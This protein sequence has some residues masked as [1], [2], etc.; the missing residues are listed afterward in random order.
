MRNPKNNDVCSK[1]KLAVF[2]GAI[3]L[4]GAQAMADVLN[5]VIGSLLYEENFNTL[6]STIWTSVD[7][8]GCEIGLCGWGNQELEYYS[9]ANLSI[10]NVPFEPATKALAIEARREAHGTHAFTSGKITS[11]NKLQVK[12][13]LIEFRM[14]T[15]QVGVG[16][17][18][19]GWMLGTSLASWPSKGEL[20]IMEMGHS[21]A[22]MAGAGLA[23]S[24]INSYTASNAIFYATSA[25]TTGNASC[26]AS[27]AWQTK[28]AYVAS[29]PLTNRF[30]T[31]RM[32]WT[33]SQIRFT[34]VDAGVEHDM[35]AA[36]IPIT[37]ESSE[38][39]APFYFL[40]NLAVGGNFTDAA[41]DAQVTAP[42]A[43]RMYIDYI[44]VYQLNGLGEVKLGSQVKP[45]TGTF[46]VFT[47][48]TPTTNKQEA[49]VS[50]DIWIWNTTSTSA[51]TT[52]AYEGSNV[53]AWKY[54]APQW[55]GG[56]IASRQARDMG[57]FI[58]GNLKF[59]IKIP[60][61]VGFKIGIS[62]TYTNENY[63]NFPANTTTYGLVRDGNWAQATVPI[64]VL[65]GS[66]VALQSL[67]S[68]F[69]IVSID[70][71]PTANFEMAID[72]IVWECGTGAACQATSSASSVAASSVPASSIAASSV[73]A[74][75]V[76]ASSKPASS[77]A[78]SS[79][80][81]SSVPASSVPA[82][83]K[84]A[85]SV[86]ASSVAASSSV[87]SGN[88]YTVLS[89]TSIRFYANNAPWADI[90]FTVNGGPQQNVRMTVSGANN[91]YD[92]T[93]LT[94]GAV[95]NYNF[96]VGIAAGGAT[97]TAWASVTCCT[98]GASSAAPSSVAASSVA[99]SSVPASSKPASSVAP[100][101]VAASSVAA[102]S[103]PASSVAASSASSTAAAYGYTKLTTTSVKFFAN[104]SPWVDIHYTVSGG[105]QINVRMTHNAD[106]TNTYTITGVPVGAV[107]TYSY[108]I[109]QT[110]GAIDT[111]WAQFNM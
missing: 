106:N 43:G 62:D 70:P 31:Y 90:H 109:G 56:G 39:Q 104:N 89:A 37:S 98:G 29:L 20:D 14:S 60:A 82:S 1:A 8:D 79:V 24:D 5:P 84:P 66:L 95:V 11:S 42:L 48:N 17:W 96:T 88:G 65:R 86:T 15:P 107:V 26:A 102:S 78:A 68:L 77:V 16:L 52:P 93:G 85:S 28:N 80:P 21:A 18:P 36:P 69:N 50:D 35:Y 4:F 9:P 13:G 67:S 51:G 38:F 27:T 40:F 111:A 94:S 30:V 59:R 57:N 110:V 74:S 71:Q 19:A 72:D 108:T 25:C 76:P 97:D 10:V 12:Y 83:S 64:S 44:R 34:V 75:S 87:A 49:G 105:A 2:A 55:F 61:N 46:G 53:I 99:P 3:A 101:S 63:I 92:I 6:D 32:Y 81:A 91:T 7:G 73:P 45:E 23:G 41:N 54:A 58:N 47:D 22:G 100:S 33:D 103:K